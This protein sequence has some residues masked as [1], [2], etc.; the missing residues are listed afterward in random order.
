MYSV[1]CTYGTRVYS[2]VFGTGELEVRY[3]RTGTVLGKHGE[4]DDERPVPLCINAS[5]FSFGRTS[6]AATGYQLR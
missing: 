5:R 1:R 3:A 4:S 2:I 6:C